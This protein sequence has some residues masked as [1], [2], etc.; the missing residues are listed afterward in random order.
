MIPLENYLLYCL[1]Y[2]GAIVTPGPGTLSIVAR[3]LATGFRATI[4]ACFGVAAGD[5]ILMTISAFG[6]SLIAQDATPALLGLKYIGSLYIIY[7][8]YRCWTSDAP[9]AEVAILKGPGRGFFTHFGITLSNPKAIAFFVALQPLAVDLERLTFAGYLQLVA[10]TIVLIPSIKMAYAAAAAR[11][12]Y[13][14]ASA[15]ARRRIRKGSGLIMT[16]AGL[17]IMVK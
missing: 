15:R 4:P 3:A 11:L 16:G 9:D 7:L 6:L 1:I 14:L 5:L 10:A 17:A 2:A 13:A 12:S 8:G